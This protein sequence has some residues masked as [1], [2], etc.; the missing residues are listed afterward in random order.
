M[1]D[2]DEL[3]RLERLDEQGMNVTRRAALEVPDYP[4][5]ITVRP[6]IDDDGVDLERADV[7]IVSDPPTSITAQEQ[8]AMRVIGQ[9]FTILDVPA[10]PPRAAEGDADA[11]GSGAG[12]DG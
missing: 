4:L 7:V 9:L 11:S 6:A 1:L 2:R 5:E 12:S 10:G 3:Y 8:D